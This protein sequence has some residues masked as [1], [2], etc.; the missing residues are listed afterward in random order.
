[1]FYSLLEQPLFVTSL[2]L[3]V[4]PILSCWILLSSSCLFILAFHPLKSCV[5]PLLLIMRWKRESSA[6]VG[7]YLVH[8]TI[9]TQSV[10][11]PNK[12]HKCN[13][14]SRKDFCQNSPWK[15]HMSIL[16]YIFSKIEKKTKSIHIC[17]SKTIIP[18][19][20]FLRFY[21]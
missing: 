9:W 6:F 12:R 16:Q 11:L 21:S 15:N 2:D 4:F 8:V 20:Y 10:C 1:M 13:L 3:R 19:W 17:A 18:M 5:T 7:L 14:I